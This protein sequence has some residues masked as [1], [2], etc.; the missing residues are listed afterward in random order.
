MIDKKPMTVNNFDF[1]YADKTKK[2][3]EAKLLQNIELALHEK[4]GQNLDKIIEKRVRQEWRAVKA[5]GYAMEVAALHELCLWMK[6][7]G[8][9][10]WL[11]ATT[12][13]SFILYLLG[14]AAAN[15]LP[16]HYLCSE[17]HTVMWSNSCK[18]GFDMA[19]GAC[20]CQKD[21]SKMLADG[22]D[23]PWQTL[24]GYKKG[25]VSLNIRIEPSSY[26]PI[27]NLLEEHWLKKIKQSAVIVEK[28]HVFYFSNISF[29]TI[30][31]GIEIPKDFHQK[32]IDGSTIQAVIPQWVSLTDTS[33]SQRRILAE[34]TC[35]SD[36]IYIYGIN[37][38]SG[39]WD[40]E[41]AFMVG[42]LGYSPSNLIAFREDIFQY[43]LEHGFG[44]I[45]SW[46]VSEQVRKGKGLP[47]F[48]TEMYASRDRWVLQRIDEVRYLMPK[49]HAIEHL[50]FKMKCMMR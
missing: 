13:G 7:E 38:S 44:E 49:A 11:N 18:S 16:A 15:P 10:Y 1:L 2:E 22:H 20:V 23:I 47:F 33:K 9:A 43:M 35:F 42:N 31:S 4:Y 28:K 5:G 29:E 8:Y 3:I 25:L 34:P 37:H 26:E 46:R 36:L 14:V 17:C 6:K 48:R 32:V 39:T 30:D 50:F 12:G 21:G 27:L 41:A 45:D 19:D 40:R 24:W